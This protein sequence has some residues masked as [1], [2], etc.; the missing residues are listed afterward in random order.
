[1][2]SICKI[3]SNGCFAQDDR[4][5]EMQE[6]EEEQGEGKQINKE[7]RYW[8]Q[9]FESLARFSLYSSSLVVPSA[10]AMTLVFPKNIL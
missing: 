4:E 3:K 8:K 9:T 1:M 6:E 10:F 2:M 5:R 7:R